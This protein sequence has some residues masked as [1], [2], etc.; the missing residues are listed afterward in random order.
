L[1]DYFCACGKQYVEK[2][3]EILNIDTKMPEYN[4]MTF[5]SETT[6]SLHNSFFEEIIGLIKNSSYL[7]VPNVKAIFLQAFCIGNN[8]DTSKYPFDLR[9]TLD[10]WVSDINSMIDEIIKLISVPKLFMKSEI[11]SIDNINNKFWN[12]YNKNKKWQTLL[13]SVQAYHWV[14]AS[15]DKNIAPQ[16]INKI[17]SAILSNIEKD[18]NHL[19]EITVSLPIY[20]KLDG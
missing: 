8:V 2:A 3:N 7:S 16:Y 19:E 17:G 10:Q 12:T 5:C 1:R 6:D 4:I 15:Y 13:Y 9:Q 18:V 20:V 11:I 14:K